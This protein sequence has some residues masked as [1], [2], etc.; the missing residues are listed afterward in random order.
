[1]AMSPAM[2][3]KARIGNNQRVS[4]WCSTKLKSWMLTMVIENPMQFT[5][6]SAEPTE[7]GGALSAFN[8]E[9]CGESPATVIPQMMRKRRKSAVGTSKRNG[10]TMQHTPEM[11]S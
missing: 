10:D 5:I 11:A 1:M 8:E 2:G 4:T 9:N 3:P 7:P 6:V